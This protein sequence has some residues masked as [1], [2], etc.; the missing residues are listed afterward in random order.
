M[1]VVEFLVCG[2]CWVPTPHFLVGVHRH[3]RAAETPQG[4]GVD[5]GG[6]EGGGNVG[7]A[8]GGV[9]AVVGGVKRAAGRLH[10]AMRPAISS[11]N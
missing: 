4:V 11:K 5:A 2:G 6:L 8:V 1:F 7:G 10:S 9:V 3:V